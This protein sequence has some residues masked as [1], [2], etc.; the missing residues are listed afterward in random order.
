[1]SEI[2][3]DELAGAVERLRERLDAVSGI[4]GKF[5][6]PRIVERDDLELVLD[7]LEKARGQLPEGMEHCTIVFEECPKG[8]GNL[9]GTNW[10][11]HPCVICERDSARALLRE[12]RDMLEF[13]P[14]PIGAGNLIIYPGDPREALRARI[15]L[16]LG[17]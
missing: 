3:A 15:A 13:K 8:H 12:A 10:I 6:R 11:K 5:Y 2:D 16:E 1:M 7:A 17:Q 9:R 4:V 14:L